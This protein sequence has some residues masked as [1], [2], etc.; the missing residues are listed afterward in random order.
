MKVTTTIK[1]WITEYNHVTPDELKTPEGVAT[2]NFSRHDM[3]MSGWTFVGDATITVDILETRALV[4]N[5]VAALREQAASIRAEATAKV[6]K[7]EGQI[8]QLLCIE[9]SPAGAA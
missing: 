8:Q 7:I 3:T 6:T 1:A 4:D 2:L 9:N 5:K